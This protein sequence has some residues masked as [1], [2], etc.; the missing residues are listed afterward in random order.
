MMVNKRDRSWDFV[1]CVLMF[2]IVFGHFCP[3]GE[4]WTPATRIVGLC[5][6]PCF[7]FVSGYF[8]SKITSGA[9]YE[10]KL[11]KVLLRIVVPMVAWG[12]FYLLA[13][14]VQ[15]YFN[16]EITDVRGVMQFFIYSPFYIAGIFWFL[17]ALLMCIVVGSL[18]SWAIS[19]HKLM[20]IV[21][22]ALSPLCF[23]VVSQPVMEK[24]HFSFIWLFYV[25]GMLFRHMH[26]SSSPVWDWLALITFVM[27]TVIGVGYEPQ[28]TF[29]YE[30]NVV[31]E[32]SVGFIVGRYVLYIAATTSVIYGLIWFYTRYRENQL[33]NRLAQAG[34]DTLFIYCSHVLVLVI[35]YRPYVLPYLFF[36][37]GW[38][39]HVT[40]HAVGLM[41]SL[42]VYWLM[43]WLCM[44]C[45]QFHWLRIVLMGTK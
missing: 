36:G 23:C 30:S 43:Q 2:L 39:A 12:M 6:I 21:L 17:T 24:Y 26:R 27:I 9:D 22:T 28:H 20:G 8:Q 40:E 41:V 5:A 29:Y 11:R 32:S 10:G 13:N 15:M 19:K 33:V 45:K 3:A 14:V 37:E 38:P 44:W 4:L 42:A 1:K 31:G 35:L 25:M 34:V 16:E 7:F 18:L